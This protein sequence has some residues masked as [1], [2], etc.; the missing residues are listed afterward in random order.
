[1][2]VIHQSEQAKQMLDVDNTEMQKNLLQRRNLQSR[3]RTNNR[4]FLIFQGIVFGDYSEFRRSTE[5]KAFHS[6]ELS[7]IKYD[8]IWCDFNWEITVD[9]PER[10]N[11]WDGSIGME[12][13]NQ[14]SA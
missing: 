4:R 1:M 2:G 14:R 11:D 12:E 6:P 3:V 9:K 7:E 5:E 10:Q 13:R 8:V